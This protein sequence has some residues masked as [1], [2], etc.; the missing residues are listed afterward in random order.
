MG[1]HRIAVKLPGARPVLGYF[2]LDNQRRPG[3]LKKIPVLAVLTLVAAMPA[4]AQI[5]VVEPAG[6]GFAN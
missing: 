6:S 4:N 5:E 3:A 1:S 2:A